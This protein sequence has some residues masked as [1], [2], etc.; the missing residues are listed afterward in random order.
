MGSL[1]FLLFY[2]ERPCV[3]LLQ[4]LALS[5]KTGKALDLVVHFPWFSWRA[6]VRSRYCGE[7]LF[8]SLDGEYVLCGARL[9]GHICFCEVGMRVGLG[10]LALG[11]RGGRFQVDGH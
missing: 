11:V 10:V 8:D 5:L 6:A 7:V 3:R 2:G 1:P 4:T 9:V